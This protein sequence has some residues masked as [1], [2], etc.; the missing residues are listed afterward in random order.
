[1]DRIRTLRSG[2]LRSVERFPD[3]DALAIGTERFTYRDLHERAARAA[4]TLDRHAKPGEG[5]LT[6]VFGH[7]HRA[8]FDGI[9]GAL[10]R[11]HGYVPLNPSFPTDRCRSMLVR[12]HCRSVVV[13]PTAEDQIDALLEGVEDSL[14]VLLPEA[15]DVSA[16]RARHPAHTILGAKDLAPASECVLG[17]ASPGDVA[18]LLFT[19]GSTGRPKGVG[20]LHRNVNA[21][22]DSMVE[23]YAITENDRFSNTFD[24][25]FD[26]SVFDLFCAWERG[27]CVCVP[28]AQQKMFP[29]KYVKQHALTVWFSVPSTGVLMSKLKMLKP[30]TYETLRWALFCGE[31]LPAEVIERFAQAAPNA[32]AENLYGPTELTIACTLYRWD[33]A[34]SPAECELGVVPIGDPYPGMVAKIVDE[35]LHEVPRGEPGELVMTGTQRAPGYWEDE[36]RTAAAFVKLP[37]DDRIF[38]RTGDRV[39]W[40]EGAPMVYVGRVDNQ[41]K[42]QGYRV[43]LGEIEAVLRNVAGAE[44]A[45]A[46]GWPRTASGADGIVGFVGAADGAD[47]ILERARALLPGYMQPSKIVLVDAFPLNSNGKVDRKALLA[48]LEGDGA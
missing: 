3:R 42:I 20:V 44:I 31:A 23:R 26:L 36:E 10:L 37:G 12:A 13:D 40:G 8:A 33:P 14:T 1:M 43:E 21:F 32:I 7:R 48:R 35:T 11:G 28:T 16:I 39:R 41:I 46:V 45:I 6:A 9:L 17:E 2:F 38:Y 24:L 25:T 47:A 27:A 22:L 5:K 19:S 4:A 29:G 34:R 18:Y 30:G 15:D